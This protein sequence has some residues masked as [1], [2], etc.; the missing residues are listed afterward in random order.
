M[1]IGKFVLI[2]VAAFVISSVTF[3]F[4]AFDKYVGEKRE[5][6]LQKIED[7]NDYESLKKVEDTARGM[8]ASYKN[9]ALKYEQYRDS[10]SKQE[11]E[12]G[13]QAK[14]RANQTATSYNEFIL[15]NSF[16]FENNVPSDISSELPIIP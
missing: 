1:N 10:E 7:N 8:I 3:G 2:G 12:W 13:E 6:T 5:Y 15:K 9:D 11:R 4:V 16:K 14:M